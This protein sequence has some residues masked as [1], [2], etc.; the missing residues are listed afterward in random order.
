MTKE[1]ILNAIANDKTMPFIQPEQLAGI[2]D[3]VIKNHVPSISNLDEAAEDFGKRQGLE[4]RPS[5]EKFFKAGAEWMAG[6]GVSGKI[7]MTYRDGTALI[8]C[9]LEGKT[10]D[11]VIVQILQQKRI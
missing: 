5:A 7:I 10:E 9:P 3:F 6:Q 4:L 8:E 2:V 1:E 11:K